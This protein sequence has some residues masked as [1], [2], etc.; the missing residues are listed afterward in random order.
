MKYY[1]FLKRKGRGCS[2][3]AL[4]QNEQEQL[5]LFGCILFGNEYVRTITFIRMSVWYVAEKE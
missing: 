1:T 2:K 5:L 4:A 3:V